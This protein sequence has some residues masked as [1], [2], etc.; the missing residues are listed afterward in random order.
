MRKHTPLITR[1]LL[2]LSNVR[3]RNVATVGG[4]LAHGDPHMDLPPVLMALGATLTV[5]RSEGRAQAR[6]RGAVLR[7][8]RDRAG[9]ERTDRRGLVSRRRARR[10]PP[11]EGHDRL[12]RRLAGAR[13]RGRDRC[14]R[15]RRSN[16]SVSSRAPR[17]TRRRG[18][19]SAEAVLNGKTVDDRL[20]GDARRRRIGRLRIDRRRPRLGAL[21]ARADAG[22]RAARDSVRRCDKT[23]RTDGHIINRRQREGRL[24]GRPLGAAPRRPRQGHRP[25]RIHP[26][27]ARAGHA[28]RQDLPQHGGARQDQV[29][30]HQRSHARCRACCMSSPSTT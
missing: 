9:E 1:T 2:T 29:D 21:Q 4:A 23:G 27:H 10:R 12:G 26:H 11:T 5:S 6:G 30:R 18:S 28:A 7:L 14:D 22:L 24:A 3:V 15:R 20:L 25:R 19:R 16:R 8:L 17:P 13:R